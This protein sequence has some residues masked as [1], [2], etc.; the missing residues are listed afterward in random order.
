M[1]REVLLSTLKKFE[2]TPKIQERIK[3]KDLKTVENDL[4]RMDFRFSKLYKSYFVCKLYLFC[5]KKTFYELP[6]VY[7]Q[8][9]MEIGSVV[10]DAYFQDKV[11]SL[12]LKHKEY[13]GNTPNSLDINS[14]NEKEKSIFE[15]FLKENE[16]IYTRFRN[17]LINILDEKFSFFTKNDFKNYNECNQIFIDMM[18]KK[19]KKD[20]NPLASMKY[21]NHTLTFFKRLSGNSDVAF[22]FLNI[23]L[24]SDP[25]IVFSILAVY[26]EKA[27]GITSSCFIPDAET[28]DKI[29]ITSLSENEIK[30]IISTHEVFLK[31]KNEMAN[32][33]K[34]KNAVLFLSTAAGCALIAIILSK[35]KN[36]DSTD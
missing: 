17:C 10:L 13:D 7:F 29:L 6:I 15:K 1:T 28:R 31:T 9:M 26:I 34:S 33:N 24:N 23:I 21:M 30:K 8:G 5:L 12:R 25:S 22:K 32:I 35:W 36:G 18:K 11:A 19:F 2:Y 16:G 4:N 20:I 14:I 27:D 3:V